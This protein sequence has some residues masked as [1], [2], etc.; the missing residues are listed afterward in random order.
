MIAAL[1]QFY[2]RPTA[3]ATL[4]AS[5]FCCREKFVGFFILWT[6]TRAMPFTIAQTTDFGFASPTFTILLSI[7]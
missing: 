2:H 5:F 6:F 1:L 4:P 7:L 3:I